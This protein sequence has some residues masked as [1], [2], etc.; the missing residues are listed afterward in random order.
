[1]VCPR[2]LPGKRNL[3][4]QCKSW[5]VCCTV[6]AYMASSSASLSLSTPAV[7]PELIS[8]EQRSLVRAFALFTD[9]AASLER[10]YTQLQGEVV[11]LRRELEETNRDL[12]HSLQKNRRIQQHLD[13]IV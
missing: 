4:C 5:H 8:L 3:S 11:R 10:S 12:S 2:A 6:L 7:Q 13:R 1:M 9:A